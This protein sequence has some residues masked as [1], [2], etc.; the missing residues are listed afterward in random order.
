MKKLSLILVFI[1]YSFI[2]YSQSL[3]HPLN[4]DFEYSTSGQLPYAWKFNKQYQNLGYYAYATDTNSLEGK[5]SLLI[6]NIHINKS[7]INIQSDQTLMAVVYQEVEAEKFHNLEL[8]MGAKC[9]IEK[10]SNDNFVLFFIQQESDKQGMSSTVMSDTLKGKGIV[11]GSV[12]VLIDSSTKVIKY[13]FA[14]YGLTSAMID[15]VYIDVAYDFSQNVPKVELTEN[16]LQSILNLAKF[17][18]WLKYFY[19]H[20]LMDKVN[21]ESIIYH[22]I[23]KSVELDDV[24]SFNSLL[25]NEFDNIINPKPVIIQK[26]TIKSALARV[27]SG[28]PTKIN[29]P[30]VSHKT[31]DVFVTN[32]NNP[33]VLLQFINISKEKPT[34]LE[35]TY[36][37]KF[38]KYNYNGKA[39]VWLRI[40]DTFGSSLAELKSNPIEQDVTEWQKGLLTAQIPEEAANLRIGLVLEGNGEVQFDKLSMKIKIGGKDSILTIR[41]GDFED[42]K[43]PKIISGWNMP[44]YSQDE[45]YQASITEDGYESNHSVKIYSDLQT[46]Y[47]LPALLGRYQELFYPNQVVELPLMLHPIQLNVTKMPNYHFPKFFRINERDAYSR[48]LI[49]IDLYGYIRNF[50]LNQIDDKILEQGLLNA[51]KES[52]KDINP[53]DFLRIIYKFYS[54]SGDINSK[55]WNGLENTAY[56]P[57]IGIYSDGNKIFIYGSKD[58]KIPDGSEI[59]SVDDT[60]TNEI[61][62]LKRNSK[63]QLAK[64]IAQLLAGNKNS[65]VTIKIKT[66]NG[67]TI[68]TKFKRTALNLKSL[69]KPFYATELDTGV[70]YLNTTMLS[71]QDFKNISK[72]LS[73]QDIK[74]IIF[75]LRGYSTLSEHI[76]GFFSSDSIKG[77]KAEVPVY[78]APAKSIVSLLPINSNIKPNGTLKNKKVVFLINEFTTSYSELIAYI[79]KKNNIGILVGEPSQ[80]VYSDVGQMR[81]AGYYYGSQSFIKIKDG[82]KELNEPIIPNIEVKQTLD[83]TIKGIDLQLQKAIEIINQ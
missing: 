44:N 20:P 23:K 36:Y 14:F 69:D 72:Q 25:I 71:D 64:K 41:N 51:L 13:G 52:A 9:Q 82:D 33:G 74:G 18:S 10:P 29:S 73:A 26:D 3:I 77:Y 6:K 80:G 37:Y 76:L 46:N 81:L 27:V 8:I 22:Y 43:N 34:S 60:K 56:L 79:A 30:V 54:I 35:L 11:D 15:D 57:D 31:V 70:I 28:L 61:T 12:R 53:E 19:P 5:Y 4:L 21:W 24:S 62:D 39:N 49:L 16:S 59:I 40:D 7:D 45:G 17:Y 55:F 42:I 50:S 1:T 63:Y 67:E 66:T 48:F 78:T 32:K 65:I 58:K 2:T 38:T 83:A 68:T 47:K 75:D